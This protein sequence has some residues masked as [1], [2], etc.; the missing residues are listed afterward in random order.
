V[1]TVI[2]FKNNGRPFESPHPGCYPSIQAPEIVVCNEED[3]VIDTYNFSDVLNV[4]F[5][6]EER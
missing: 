4:I 2:T 6:P 5:I 3:V 1:K